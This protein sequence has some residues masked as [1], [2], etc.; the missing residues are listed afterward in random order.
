MKRYLTAFLVIWIAGAGLTIRVWGLNRYYFNP[1]EIMHLVISSSATLADIQETNQEHT[2]APL[3]YWLFHFW[4]KISRN[5]I[6]LKSISLGS[7]TALIVVSF[8]L[9]RKA[10]GALA[11]LVMALLVA[12]SYGATLL[13]EVVRP[14]M[15]E[16]AFLS[17]ALLFLIRYWQG[18]GRKSAWAYAVFMFLAIATQYSAVIPAAA[19]GLVWFGRAV[20][21]RRLRQEGGFAILLYLVLVTA[22]LALFFPQ[23]HAVLES[24]RFQHTVSGYLAPHFLETWSEIG[25]HLWSLY[26]YLFLPPLATLFL[27]LSLLGALALIRTSRLEIPLIVVLTLLLNSILALLKY[28][29]LGGARQCAFYLPLATLL[30]GA[31]FQYGYDAIRKFSSARAGFLSGQGKK[32]EKASLGAGTMGVLLATVLIGAWYEKWD[33]LR[34][35]PFPD[36]WAKFEFCLTRQNYTRVLQYLEQKVPQNDV[37]VSN[38]GTSNYIL[39]ATQQSGLLVGRE[40][41][42]PMDFQ[43]RTIYFVH[44]WGFL[45]Q[46]LLRSTFEK[47]A[48]KKLLTP[49]TTLWLFNI[50]FRDLAHQ[51]AADPLLRGAVQQTLVLEGSYLY[52]LDSAAILSG[53]QKTKHRRRME[54]R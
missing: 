26:T 16:T 32:L 35:Y 25:G 9:G 31:A 45:N 27:V 17:L 51:T 20:G 44:T 12:F 1:D 39:W 14:Y 6:F 30:V 50:G 5:E 13:S 22:V 29:P 41:V 40:F 2:H 42:T 11:G 4:M 3:M 43:G 33:F 23:V 10:S 7:G 37:V 47:L 19:I 15:L 54:S 49:S 53:L 38:A 36:P 18:A 34:N 46:N 21:Q 48:R 24:R 28:Y 8:L 52:A